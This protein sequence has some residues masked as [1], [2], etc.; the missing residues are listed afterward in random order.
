VI[1]P[2]NENP[3][4]FDFSL[5]KNQTVIAKVLGN[6][7]LEYRERTAYYILRADAKQ[8]LFILPENIKEFQIGALIAT[9]MVSAHERYVR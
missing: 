1:L 2:P 3:A 4:D 8:V 5:F 6:C 7:E 9:Q